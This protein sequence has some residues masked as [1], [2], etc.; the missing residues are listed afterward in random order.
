MNFIYF[1]IL[2]F[3][4]IFLL[5]I[6]YIVFF[7]VKRGINERRVSRLKSELRPILDQYMESEDD[8]EVAADKMDFIRKKVR[9]KIGLKAFNSIYRER[10]EQ[11]GVTEKLHRFTNQFI[12]FH[13][14]YNNRIVFNRYRKS[15]ILY[16][17][18]E[19]C[20]SS[21][22]VTRFALESL[23]D[24]SLFVRNNALRV[25]RNIGSIDVFIEAFRM[26][27]KGDLYFNN[28]V[29]VDYMGNFQ[30]DQQALY[31][32]L[33]MNIAEFSTVIQKNIIDNF[34][35]QRVTEFSSHIL[36][37]IKSSN[38]PELIISG[39]KYFGTIHNQ[40]AYEFIVENFAS[41]NYAIRAASATAIALY[42]G[43]KTIDVLKEHIGDSDW[44]VRYNCASTL[45]NLEEG[46]I[47]KKD[48]PIG[49]IVCGNDRF[50]KEII[51]YTLYSKGLIGASNYQDIY[52]LFQD[53]DV[54]KEEEKWI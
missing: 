13:T 27:T 38:D 43:E 4:I 5:I 2:F 47:F 45:V 49:E 30:G 31:K 42:P 24:K 33:A 53:E 17:C 32:A 52:V 15:Y 25:L 14:L 12:D 50:A 28:K 41:E 10:V 29:L 6:S 39:I 54:K 7:K 18:A 51:A 9:T 11:E 36:R 37:F 23:E 40:E 35:N 20:L 19:Y 21:E 1:V 26:I 34:T 3:F 44:Y 16:L 48:G 8:F 22:E 46:S